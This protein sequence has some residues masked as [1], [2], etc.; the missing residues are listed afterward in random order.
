MNENNV[1]KTFKTFDE[2]WPF[3]LRE[4]SNPQCR[5]MHVVGTTSAITFTLVILLTQ[6]IGWIFHALVVGY[7]FAWFGHYQYQKNRPATFKYP[8][9]S[10][11]GDMKMYYLAIT[12]EL[13]KELEK[14]S[15]KPH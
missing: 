13:D 3:Y 4:H 14:L 5:L 10:F 11:Q 6:D 15:I 2:F 8:W 12:G 1:E 7:G 9:M